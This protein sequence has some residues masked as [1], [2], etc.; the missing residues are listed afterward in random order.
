MKKDRRWLKSAL[1]AS[2]DSTIS[3]PWTRGNRRRPLAM[4]SV[5][6]GTK[7]RASAAR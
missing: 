5:S 6:T 4:K 2:Q 1:A 3:M 7:P